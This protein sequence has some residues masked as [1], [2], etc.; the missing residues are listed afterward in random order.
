MAT[1][2]TRSAGYLE[3]NSVNAAYQRLKSELNSQTV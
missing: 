2:K 1:N 3:D